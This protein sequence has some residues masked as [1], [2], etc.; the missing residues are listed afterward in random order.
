M[1]TNFGKI[2]KEIAAQIDDMAIALSKTV[3]ELESRFQEIEND[4]LIMKKHYAT[5]SNKVNYL[6]KKVLK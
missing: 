5:L 1:K 6:E 2:K 4:H 3:N